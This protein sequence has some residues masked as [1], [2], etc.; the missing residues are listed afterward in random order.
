[1]HCHSQRMTQTTVPHG[2]AV[3]LRTLK[4]LGSLFLLMPAPLVVFLPL[5]VQGDEAEGNDCSGR[6]GLHVSCK[7]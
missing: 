7:L 3:I 6:L 1:M 2:A 5:S 4:R